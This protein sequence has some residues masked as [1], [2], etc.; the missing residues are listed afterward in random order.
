MKSSDEEVFQVKVIYMNTQKRT[1]L[2]SLKETQRRGLER[3]IIKK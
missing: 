1:E 3:D 2:K